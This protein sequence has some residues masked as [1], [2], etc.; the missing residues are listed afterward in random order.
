ML[1]KCFKL[2]VSDLFLISA[3]WN[4]LLGFFR[5]HCKVL[6]PSLTL[7]LGMKLCLL[8]LLVFLYVC[9]LCIGIT[10]AGEPRSSTS[11]NTPGLVSSAHVPSSTRGLKRLR[12][13][14]IVEVRFLLSHITHDIGCVDVSGLIPSLTELDERRPPPD[15]RKE[16]TP[17]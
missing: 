4:H 5:L 15:P 2:A 8:P 17:C 13:S 12:E 3:L 7:P 1:L 11:G 9:A 6:V 14:D 10:V 16:S